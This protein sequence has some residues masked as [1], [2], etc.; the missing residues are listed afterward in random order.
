MFGTKSN[1]VFFSQCCIIIVKTQA[2]LF[3]FLIKAFKILPKLLWLPKSLW[4]PYH[5]GPGSQIQRRWGL[6]PFLP[7]RPQKRFIL[8]KKKVRNWR[9]QVVW[10]A[11]WVDGV[12][13]SEKL[14]HQYTEEPQNITDSISTTE[15]KS[16]RKSETNTKEDNVNN[17]NLAGIKTFLWIWMVK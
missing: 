10:P 17:E 15:K 14:V 3:M 7:K 9:S 8:K 13:A 16:E 4:S 2:F 5:G 1:H 6:Y 12:G 11:G